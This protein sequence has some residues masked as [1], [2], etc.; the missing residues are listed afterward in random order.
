M[1]DTRDIEAFLAVADE[2]HFGRAASRLRLTTSRVSQTIRSLERKIGAPLFERSSRRTALTPLGQHLADQLRPA[3]EQLAWVIEDAR[4]IAAHQSTTLAIGF[5]G[6][7]FPGMQQAIVERYQRARSTMRIVAIPVNPLD[8]YR[9]DYAEAG[10]DAVVGWVSP[11]TPRTVGPLHTGPAI[12]RETPALLMSTR[13]PLA[14][15]ETVSVD[16]LGEHAVLDPVPFEDSTVGW[17]PTETPDGVTTRRVRR[18]GIRYFEQILD[19]I[20]RG[21]LMHLTLAHLDQT[22]GLDGFTLIPLSDWKPFTCRV[23]WQHSPRESVVEDFAS[24]AARGRPVREG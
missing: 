3:Y 17:V 8:M 15:N 1:L 24:I 19:E 20:R 16:V 14:G 6:T 21:A 11:D 23:L 10:L 22:L 7:L 5:S 13:H 12:R 4:E 2:L 18:E 9:R